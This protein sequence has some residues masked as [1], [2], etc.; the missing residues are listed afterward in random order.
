MNQFTQ[1]A[2]QLQALFKGLTPQ[3]RLLSVLL[4]AAIAVSAAVLFNSASVGNGKTTYLFDGQSFSDYEINR[5]SIAFSNASL[6][7]WEREGDRVKI[8]ANKKEDYYKAISEAKVQPDPMGGASDAAV[9]GANIFESTRVTEAKQQHAKLKD[10]ANAL[11]G[12]AF[13]EDAFV[14]SDEKRQGFAA[15][16]QKTASIAVRAK[17]GIPLSRDQTLSIMNY[18]QKSMAGLGASDIALLDLASGQTTLGNDDPLMIEQDRYYQVK[19]QQELDLKRRAKELLADYGDIRLEVN[20]E[21]DNTLS[22]EQSKMNYDPK[23][24]TIQSSTSKKDMD[25]SKTSVQGRPGADPN[26]F[27]NRSASVSAPDQSTKGKESTE[28]VKQVVGSN[29]TNIKKAGLQTRYVSFSVLV[30][31]SYYRKIHETEWREQ[32]PTEKDLSKLPPMTETL[33]KSLKSKVETQIQN[34]LTAIIQTSVAGEDKNPR[35]N[36]KHYIDFPPPELPTPSMSTMAVYWLAQSWQTLTLA[37]IALVAVV[38]L[39]SFVASAPSSDDSAFERGFDLPL[40]D[41]SEIDLSGL[42]DDEELAAAGEE[43]GEEGKGTPRFKLSGGELKT[44]L[45]SM[46]RENP[47]AA[48]TLLRNW[49][50]GTTG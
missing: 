11:K 38:S 23:P 36:V 34:A 35:V 49:I 19:K 45:T 2:Q 28:N 47:D 32:N 3:A 42:T 9:N 1:F 6:R 41:A 15:L 13:I 16:R 30:P 43:G 7:D 26:A 18:V 20:V 14:T 48:A 17:G 10:I 33:L 29:V 25:S 37:L 12:M 21:L 31:Y 5:F 39:R 50:A 24:T 27:S 46:V 40:D 8:P 22:E 44:D 4:A